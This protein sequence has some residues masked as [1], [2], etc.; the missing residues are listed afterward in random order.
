MA[1]GSERSAAC[2]SAATRISAAARSTRATRISTTSSTL[3][4]RGEIGSEE[5]KRL[6]AEA[7]APGLLAS[8]ALRYFGSS[9]RVAA[10][11]E[12]FEVADVV[13]GRLQHHL[14]AVAERD[15]AGE[16][17]VAEDG[18]VAALL[19]RHQ[20]HAVVGRVVRGGADH[21]LRHH[22]LHAGRLRGPALED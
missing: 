5:S 12:A 8:W 16:V 1:A 11:D 7:V 19:L 13:L 3:V 2:R 10:A 6:R 15:D 18:E 17:A 21:V 20:R 14:H 22:L 4:S 9:V